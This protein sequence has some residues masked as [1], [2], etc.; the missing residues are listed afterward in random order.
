M[1]GRASTLDPCTGNAVGET[2]R[3]HAEQLRKRLCDL[4]RR[5]NDETAAAETWRAQ[6]N[7]LRSEVDGIAPGG[8]AHQC[9]AAVS[10]SHGNAADEFFREIADVVELDAGLAAETCDCT[11]E[12]LVLDIRSL[13]ATSGMQSLPDFQYDRAAALTT[14]VRL[15][16]SRFL[17]L[18]QHTLLALR[19]FCPQAP[20]DIALVEDRDGG[21]CRIRFA[22]VSACERAA[23]EAIER[24]ACATA[25]MSPV[26]P[27]YA[28]AAIHQML[29]AGLAR[30]MT[31][32]MDF[33]C[34]ASGSVRI[35][36][37][38]RIS[39]SA[40]P[41]NHAVTAGAPLATENP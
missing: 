14:L 19:E 33:F 40:T 35:E 31:L 12:R 41:P 37:V 10:Q 16:K 9:A 22:I 26:P 25:P 3:P 20:I 15:D 18:I 7:E 13:L 29:A 8:H 39:E 11:V 1:T 6:L 4:I 2:S 32:P 30:A 34:E 23:V 24:F 21:H 5:L 17:R 36:M 28:A 27:E 38:L